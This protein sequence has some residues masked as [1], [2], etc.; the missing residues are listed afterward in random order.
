MFIEK[1]LKK[2]EKKRKEKKGEKKRRRKKEKKKLALARKIQRNTPIE[3][4]GIL[5]NQPQMSCS[6]IS[7]IFYWPWFYDG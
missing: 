5:M 4:H 6:I 3:V 1:K 2:K 7:T